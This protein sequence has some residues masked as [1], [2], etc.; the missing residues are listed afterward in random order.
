M[1]EYER[2]LNNQTV[3]VLE[4][5]TKGRFG[6]SSINRITMPPYNSDIRNLKF[7]KEVEI[8]TELLSSWYNGWLS[9]TVPP[10]EN[11]SWGIPTTD[12]S[13]DILKK[14]GLI[15]KVRNQHL[16]G[17]CYAVTLAQILSD[18]HVVSG[19]VSWS[20]NVS[21]TSLMACFGGPKPCNGGNPAHLSRL[22]SL[23][24]VMDQTC[25]DYSWCSGDALCTNRNGGKDEFNVDYTDRLNANV[26]KTCDGCYFNTNRKYKYKFDAPGELIHNG[27][28]FRL[29][30]KTMVKRHILQY[31][32]VIGSF[33]VYPN[34]NKF[35]VYGQGLNDGVY[36]EN[37]NYRLNMPS[38]EWNTIIGEIRGFHAVSIMGWGVAKNIEYAS[39][40]F[41]DVPYW[42]CR[43]SY[44][45]NTGSKGYFKMAMHPFNTAGG[46]MDSLF[47]V[48]KTRSLGGI[49]L[50]KST[51]PP[52][53]IEPNKISETR[54]K[55][56]KRIQD[57]AFYKADPSQTRK[58]FSLTSSPFSL[59]YLS[60]WILIPVAVIC[61]L[62]IGFILFT[63]SRGFQ[64][65]SSKSFLVDE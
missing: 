46:Q 17:S 63:P 47:S 39:G 58:I 38:M 8:P 24:G 37:G 48:G 44:G 61:L 41:G 32:P 64:R 19:A 18:C 54:L 3:E 22:I 36:F 56:I 62:I 25:I 65:R 26:P 27:G 15:G 35:L 12:D 60:W 31:G 6:T 16:C 30:Y 42:H 45:T 53:E 57:D 28:Q 5:P 33:A 2:I 4:V 52:I 43:N 59:S 34:F 11:F 10:P 29:T 49:I 1:D 40:Q 9:T 20:P 13:S 7:I 14:K 23:E 50:L 51:S 55:T 21:T